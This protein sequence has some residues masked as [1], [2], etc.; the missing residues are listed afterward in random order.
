MSDDRVVRIAMWSGPRNISTAMMR[1]FGARAD[2]A[3]TDEPFY[4]AYLVASGLIHPMR[5]DV[6]ASQ[7]T[8]LAR[9]G[10]E[11]P[12]AAP[13]RK[14]G[15]VPEA[16]DASH[17][18]RVRAR[19]DR[20]TRQR[21]PHPRARGRARV[22]C[23]QAGRFHARRD[24]AAGPGRAVR[25]RC[26]PAG[27]RAAGDRGAGRAR[28]PARGAL[29]PVRR[30]RASLST[31]RCCRGRPGD[32]RPTASGRRSGIRPW[33]SRPASRRRGRRSAS[34]PCPTS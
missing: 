32:A 19:L 5:D 29:R 33:N 23:A 24:R 2:C 13:G 1:S 26:R 18:A 11:A 27:P 30:G 17:A 4:A 3:V 20:R 14:N 34:T 6:I 16:H 7:P 22:L 15:L 12:R 25:P 10:R 31:R 9:R 8:R 21:V 28:E